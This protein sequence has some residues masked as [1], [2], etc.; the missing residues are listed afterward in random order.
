MNP[1][2]LY[3]NIFIASEITADQEASGYPDDNLAD[4]RTY[5]RWKATSSANQYITFTLGS[6]HAADAIGFAG[7]NLGTIGA[8]VTIQYYSGSW[9]T[10]LSIGTMANDKPYVGL[11][12]S[13][14][15]SQWRIALT[16]MS[17][18][19]E[20]GVIILGSRLTME[21]GLAEGWDPDNQ[22]TETEGVVAKSGELLQA[23][24]RFHEYLLSAEFRRLTPNWVESNLL[25][26][27][28]NH[29]GLMKPFFFSWEPA[30]HSDEVRFVHV[31]DKPSLQLPYDPI[32]RSFR[33]SMRGVRY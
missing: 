23:N 8:S 28:E 1:V 4:L 9:L 30:S 3:N 18:T 12:T 31:T 15:S 17:G 19:P 22:Q 20:I 24:V 13:Q 29:L 2:I 33:L 25:P 21:K 27:W 5:L 7:H 14:S 32:R 6:S 10:A 16:A 11:F 26:A